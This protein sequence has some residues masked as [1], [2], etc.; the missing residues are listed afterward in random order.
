MRPDRLR[1]RNQVLPVDR[2]CIHCATVKL[3]SRKWVV[4]VYVDKSGQEVQFIGCK[5]C[6]MLKKNRL[7]Q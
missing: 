5:S 1:K 3:E 2:L 6:W 7:T 4:T